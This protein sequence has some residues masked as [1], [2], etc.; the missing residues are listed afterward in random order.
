MPGGGCINCF[1]RVTVRFSQLEPLLGISCD[2]E[3]GRQGLL[4]L[5]FP[6][7]PLLFA[8]RRCAA[9]ARRVGS[10]K[11]GS[12]CMPACRARQRQPCLR[13]TNPC[14]TGARAA[15]PQEPPVRQP[16]RHRKHHRLHHAAVQVRWLCSCMF[17]CLII[18]CCEGLCWVGRPTLA[19]VPRSPAVPARRLPSCPAATRPS[20]SGGRELG[21]L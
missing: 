20:S 13:P 18:C 10:C 21:P 12:P 14:T 16:E 4:L 1:Y 8:G 19:P 6:C 3:S 5:P 2:A 9:S 15:V 7:A 11:L 17:V